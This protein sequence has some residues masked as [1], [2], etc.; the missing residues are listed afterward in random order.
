M[1]SEKILPKVEPSEPWECL[2]GPPPNLR[3]QV[4][5]AIG[6]IAVVGAVVLALFVFG[7]TTT[8]KTVKSRGPS[9]D[10][11]LPNSG[12]V[13]TNSQKGGYIIT[14]LARDR[15]NG[16]T[17]LYGAGFIPANRVDDGITSGPSNYFTIDAE[18]MA[19]FG[20]MDSRRKG[21]KILPQ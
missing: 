12:L 18:H 21:N 15:Y 13:G 20:I 4:G 3:Q 11:N 14:K 1:K 8:P 6:M 10:G 2:D 16:L 19:R 5:V 17:Q 7:C 9:L